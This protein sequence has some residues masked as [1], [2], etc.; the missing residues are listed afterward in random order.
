MD[1]ARFHT[2][3]NIGSLLEKHGHTLLPP[4]PYSP[5]FNPFEQTFAILE[6]RRPSPPATHSFEKTAHVPNL[7]GTTLPEVIPRFGPWKRPPGF[8]GGR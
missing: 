5:D 1:N 3:E 7:I 2:K 6:K 4:P 8:H